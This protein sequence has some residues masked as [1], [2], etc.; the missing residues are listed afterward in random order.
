MKLSTGTWC[1]ACSKGIWRISRIETSVVNYDWQTRDWSSRK[2]N[3][4]FLR[5]IVGSTFKRSFAAEVSDSSLVFPLGRSEVSQ[6]EEFLRMN[7]NLLDQFNNYAAPDPD[8]IYITLFF[9]FARCW[10]VVSKKHALRLQ[11]HL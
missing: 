2:Q 10:G 7:P 6:F 4:I 11:G 9:R 5:R 8:Y 1:R 3:L